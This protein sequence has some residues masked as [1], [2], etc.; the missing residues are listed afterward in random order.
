M[1][2]YNVVQE[3]RAE[4]QIVIAEENQS[5]EHLEEVGMEDSSNTEIEYINEES[6]DENFSE[7]Q[8]P[9]QPV[10]P[11]TSKVFKKT[12]NLI[13]TPCNY[14]ECDPTRMGSLQKAK[15]QSDGTAFINEQNAPFLRER[16][17]ACIAK[18]FENAYL[19]P[20]V[21]ARGS[22]Y[23]IKMFI[24]TNPPKV[25]GLFECLMCQNKTI[26]VCYKHKDGKFKQWINS[27]VLRHVE[28]THKN[29]IQ[30]KK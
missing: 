12:I 28:L 13:K 23:N 10:P 22:L 5:T 2:N 1:L 8:P 7:E 17:E 20:G 21:E 24:S 6:E 18:I 16:L 27:N 3:E 14:R 29:Q 26:H 30:G 11:S 15:C 4:T 25:K 19:E 9:P